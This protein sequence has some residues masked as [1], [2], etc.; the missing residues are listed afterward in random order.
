MFNLIWQTGIVNPMTN[1]LILL[2]QFLGQNFVL[3]LVAF[4]ALTRLIML[5]L[6]IRQQ[7]AMAKQQELQPEIQ[8]IQKKYKS[9]PARMQE[10]FQKLG[11]NPAESLAGC[12]PLLIQMPIFFGL[13]RAIQFMMASTPQGIY[14]LSERAYDF[15]D[16]GRLLPVDNQ[17]LW[18]NMA[19]PDPLFIL[20]L[21]VGGTMFLQQKLMTPKK[22]PPKK[23]ADPDP[24]ASVQQSMMVTMPLMFGFFALQFPA[25]LSVYF[26]ISNLIG[27]VQGYVMKQNREKLQA[28]QAK[29]PKRPKVIE[30]ELSEDVDAKAAE[31]A[32]RK[33]AAA[34]AKAEKAAAKA[35]S[36]DENL[37]SN[38]DLFQTTTGSFKSDGA[39]AKSKSNASSRRKKKR[40]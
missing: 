32:A 31:K 26:V 3:A 29:R 9:D 6:N 38:S 16:L 4:T 40:R 1:L 20:P 24:T 7:R 13:Y 25:G 30:G 14:Q 36:S 23:G 2:Y 27:I 10:E 5:P 35:K 28:E 15:V 33:E 19:Q 22:T 37:S 11:Y 8:A 39:G 18:L 17:F 21:L 34:K 12:L